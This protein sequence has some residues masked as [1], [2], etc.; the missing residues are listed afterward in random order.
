M[1]TTTLQRRP[2]TKSLR[3]EPVNW[4][5]PE[6]DWVFCFGSDEPGW[7]GYFAPDDELI[8]TQSVSSYG[9]TTFVRSR[10]RL[11]GPS[12]APP[13]GWRWEAFAFVGLD[14]WVFELLPG[15]TRDLTDLAI[16]AQSLGGGDLRFGLRVIGPSLAEPVNLEIPA[17]YIDENVLDEAEGLIIANR[18]PE[19]GGTGVPQD[20]VVR[21]DLMDS[22]GTPDE[23]ETYI[24][25]EGVLAYDGA[26]GAQPGFTINKTAPYA[27]VLRFEITPDD[28]FPSQ[29]VIEVRVV[30]Q[31]LLVAHTI[32]S[33]WS[34][35]IEDLTAPVVLEAVSRFHDVVR[36]TFD[37]PVVGADVPGVYTFERLEGPDFPSVAVEAV[38]VEQVSPTEYDVTLDVPITRG[39]RYRVIVSGDVED[40]HGNAVV[41]PY[42]DAE[43]IGYECAPVAGRSFD[44][45]G[46][47]PEF[48]RR[49]DATKDLAR[50]IAVCQEVVDLLLCDIDRWTEIIDVDIA[51]E[52]YLDQMLILLGNPFKFDLS[53]DEK[54]RLIRTLVEIYQLKGTKVG[55]ISVI[56]FFLGIEVEILAF[57]E[58]GWILGVSDLGD[59]TIL[60]PGT[61]RER[62]SFDVEAPI[63][64]TEEQRQQ[65]RDLVEYMKPAHTHLVRLIE[66][67][68]PEVIDHLELGLS[69]LGGSEWWLH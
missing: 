42:D 7:E 47:I 43:F 30:S 69:E 60:G 5:A 24:Y 8:I 4:T 39:A 68:D 45:W 44:L 49:N 9:V 28:V 11:R 34:F 14:V 27:G 3:I 13:T 29:E 46:M 31:D 52:R 17:F 26:G 65:I 54:R 21:F 56:R 10:A 1:A 32:D 18:S 53:P 33:T 19:A 40:E 16:C 62:Y 58:E 61:S 12:V 23:D 25:I 35:T 22:H 59:D 55:I 66:P 48:N 38:S 36:V 57:T 63:V 50:F 67:E 51:A 20:E 15:E 41:A 6:G 37:E 2:G 64:L